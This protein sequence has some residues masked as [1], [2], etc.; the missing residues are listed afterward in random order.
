MEEKMPAGEKMP[1]NRN[2]YEKG[3][4]APE[5]AAGRRIGILCI[6]V[7]LALCLLT[8]FFLHSFAKADTPMKLL[9]WQSAWLVGEDGTLTSVDPNGPEI[10]TGLENGESCRFSTV[11]E[12]NGDPAAY[13]YLLLDTTGAEMTV[14]INGEE[15]FRSSSTVSYAAESTESGQVHIPLPQN[16]QGCTIETDY[17]LIDPDGASYVPTV[18]ISSRMFSSRFDMGYA[19]RY[20]IPAGIFGLT[21]IIICGIFLLGLALN[22]P[23]RT[24]PVLALA[25]GI[26]TFY[27]ISVGCGYYFLPEKLNR[28]LT[29]NGFSLLAPTAIL[30]YLL[31][32]RKRHFWKWLGCVSLLSVILL[33]AACLISRFH[34]GG[35]LAYIR[36]IFAAAQN[37][38]FANLLYWL[39]VYLVV[40][41]A[42]ISAAGFVRSYAGKHADAITLALKNDM[43]MESYRYMEQQLSQTAILRHEWKNQVAALHLMQRQG[44]LTQIGEY[45]DELDE[46]LRHLSPRNY[47]ENFAVNCILQG[48]AARAEEK[49]IDFHA[50]AFLPRKLQIEESDLCIFLYN[51]LDNALEA[52]AQ[53]QPPQKRKIA[54]TIRL[55]QGFFAVR[56]ENTYSGR[57]LTDGSGKIRTRKEDSFAHGFGLSQIESVVKKYHGILDISHTE[58]VFHIEAALKA[59]KNPEGP[60]KRSSSESNGTEATGTVSGSAGSA[61]E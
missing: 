8:F 44:D 36:D 60:K 6:L 43:T 58:E 4:H 56:C 45:L 14:R 5:I 13:G 9:V 47:T 57:I 37:G 61:D 53:V 51:L 54:V 18:R 11:L 31:L 35:L 12:E 50:N 10:L 2:P 34:G 27:W 17:R 48:T 55:N 39:T 7:F 46:R 24:L 29:W 28:L 25:A 30:I 15:V 33:L 52:A 42:G 22:T 32:N 20:S 16:A 19:A 23:D 38:I 1:E 59:G 3:R 21:F 41:C 49:D 40:V 26:L